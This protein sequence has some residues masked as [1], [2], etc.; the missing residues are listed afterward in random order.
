M[1]YGFFR[2]AAASLKLRV[3]DPQYNK[4]EIK[5]AIDLALKED[6][7]LRYPRAFDNRLYLR[8]FVF[9]QSFAESRRRR[10]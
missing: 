6:V 7:R 10:D 3:A 1:N 4:G 2:V 5:K 8:R 9:Y